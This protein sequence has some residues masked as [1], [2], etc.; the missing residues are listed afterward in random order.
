MD[1]KQLSKELHSNIIKKFKRRKVF[2]S[3]IDQTWSADLVNM[4]PDKNYKYILTV[5]DVF[6]K[7]S[8][9]VPLKTKTGVEITEAFQKIF[10]DSGRMPK[11]LWTDKGVEFYNKTFLK[12]LNKNN[13]ELYSTESEIKGSVIERYNRS[14]KDLMYKK[15]TELDPQNSRSD[16]WLHILPD[17]VDEYNN[18]YHSTIRM[19]PVE[20]SKKKMNNKF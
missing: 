20:G 9:C 8:F 6:S 15:F 5:I 19:T 16:K 12:F 11:K 7:Y 17:I 1:S 3:G 4:S 10:K 14:I 2:V 13:I 18:R